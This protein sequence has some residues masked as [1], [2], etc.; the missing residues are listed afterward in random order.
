VVPAR[1]PIGNERALVSG[2]SAYG[3]EMTRVKVDG[4]G[5]YEVD[6]PVAEVVER[7]SGAGGGR[8]SLPLAGG[9]VVVINPAAAAVIEIRDGTPTTPSRPARR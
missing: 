1:P 2:C 7:V 8:F 5:P 6:M 4:H 9:H 3:A